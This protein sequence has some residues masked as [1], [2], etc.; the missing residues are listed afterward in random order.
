ML[1]K[2]KKYKLLIIVA[3]LFTTIW[4]ISILITRNAYALDED[5]TNLGEEQSVTLQ[6]DGS[7]Y[8]IENI[9]DTDGLNNLKNAIE[10]YRKNNKI[11]SYI[12]L[13]ED[14]IN[15]LT[16]NA[17]NIT[18]EDIS[19]T[20]YF[21]QNKFYTDKAH[22]TLLLK[23][24]NTQ[25][26]NL[27]EVINNTTEDLVVSLLTQYNVT[28]N[29][30]WEP[31]TN[32]ILFRGDSD[33]YRF[34]EVRNNVT[35]NMKPAETGSLT[36]DGYRTKLQTSYTPIRAA[37]G[38]TIN[39][40]DNVVIKEFYCTT[41]GGV[42]Y[43]DGGTINIYGGIF[44]NNKAGANGGFITCNNGVF[45]IYD[46]IFAKNE[47][48]TGGGVFRLNFTSGKGTVNFV[49]GVFVDN[50][51]TSNGG[52]IW[53]NSGTLKIENT[54]IYNNYS[55]QTGGVIYMSSGEITLNNSLVYNNYAE[56]N[57][58]VVYISG[59]NL[60]M[61]NGYIGLPKEDELTLSNK[62]NTGSGGAL[63][64]NGGNV[65]INDGYITNNEALQGDGGALYV[66][67]G[68]F[69]F[70]K[71]NISNNT[72]NNGGGVYVNGGSV[73]VNDGFIEN[74]EALQNGGG[75]YATSTNAIAINILGGNILNNK[76]TL[77]GGGIGIDV[78]STTTSTLN[79]GGTSTDSIS[80]KPLYISNNTSTNSGGGMSIHGNVLVNVFN[81][82]INNNK[83]SLDGGG[84]NV[85]TGGGVV[86]YG[87]NIYKN[88]STSNG[89]GVNIGN[90]GKFTM[91]GG[92][93]KENESTSGD[94]G[95][96][97]LNSGEFKVEEGNINN[98]KALNGGGAYV[99]SATFTL[100]G[101]EFN[102]NNATLNGGGFFIGND[103]NVTLS[104]GEVKNNTST[105]GAGFYQTETTGI[106]KTLLSGECSV[107]NN[108][109][110]LGNGGGIY[111]DGGSTFRLTGGKVTY[112]KST[113]ND[114]LEYT[115]A[116]ESTSGVGGG[117]YIK[118][119]IFSMYDESDNPGT[120]AIYGNTAT[121]AAD[122]FFAT[123]ENTSFDAISVIAMS[124]DD[125]YKTADSWFED[126]PINE[127]H[128]TLNY[129]LRNDNDSNND[130]VISKGRY[131]DNDNIEDK[132]TA[133]TVLY[134]NC[135]DYIA[136]TM[137]NSIGSLNIKVTDDNVSSEHTFI[138]KIE[139]CLNDTCTKTNN[140]TTINVVVTKGNN[141]FIGSV[142]SGIY[143]ISLI[144][145]WSWRFKNSVNYQ[146]T[147]NS[148]K[149]D[150][151]TNN[152]VIV[153][154]Y[155]EQTTDVETNYNYNNKSWLFKSIINE[156]INKG[157]S[158]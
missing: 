40:H 18:T 64:V 149:K 89:A 9:Y 150:K 93:I 107:T 10:E 7:N 158:N 114:S 50:S 45:N 8:T 53:I 118:E 130:L 146:V 121:F 104:D 139:S 35:L 25:Y 132:I 134:R 156:W 112:N 77:E 90:D 66:K 57:G 83:T 95:G 131:K 38:S 78:T 103:S 75:I 56:K 110:K 4:S 123:G 94:G 48:A 29:E 80:S 14:T 69:T 32:I 97:Y 34:I 73:T 15:L 47:A 135:K 58:G 52:A 61:N 37:S 91:L 86:V 122:D 63:Y 20:I 157:G 82:E 147:E 133:T 144:S 12:D 129:D 85:S 109:A 120:A 142:P 92:S 43:L 41:N 152:S 136:I 148:I 23:E 100:I 1:R 70:N 19:K 31:S 71:G 98:N 68:T 5:L 17:D 141:T 140:D 119:G 24:D 55:T 60:T 59:G 115:K 49:G 3:L 155:T 65:L 101:G 36:L 74:N 116:K 79:I 51:S 27:E 126:F 102:G 87:G 127:E 54:T 22:T 81:G 13:Y 117:V 106:T 151:G 11:N 16:T 2:Y 33:G 125:A 72:S 128:I 154:I 76:A 143:K 111:I 84:I 6:I 21:Y 138:Y 42:M 28:A 124:K 96:I 67:T 153:N 145:D 137:G 113:S 105:N 30:S 88:I 62:S 26:K 46:G 39:I 44:Y 99:N 108:Q